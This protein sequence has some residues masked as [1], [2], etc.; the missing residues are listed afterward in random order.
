MNTNDSFYLIDFADA[1]FNEFEALDTD[2][3]FY[4]LYI[5][6]LKTRSFLL[7]LDIEN[8]IYQ[9]YQQIVVLTREAYFRLL[10][11][12]QS[13]A[14]AL[15]IVQTEAFWQKASQTFD[16]LLQLF[17]LPPC[18]S[19]L[20]CF[21]SFVPSAHIWRDFPAVEK[22]FKLL[23]DGGQQAFG[24]AQFFR[25]YRK[26]NQKSIF[27]LDLKMLDPGTIIDNVAKEVRGRGTMIYEVIETEMF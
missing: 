13:V 7:A 2:D 1:I 10:E 11:K 21:G 6:A 12:P 4:N 9:Q 23:T 14:A 15:Q 24:A 18:P 8:K 26:M 20:S 19:L 22:V 17:A 25:K 16:T 5:F 27:Q 3:L